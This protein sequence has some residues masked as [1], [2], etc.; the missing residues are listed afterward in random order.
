ML[1]KFPS[2]NNSSS[3]RRVQCRS[4]RSR[5]GRTLPLFECTQ[6]PFARILFFRRGRKRR[7]LISPPTLSQICLLP[8]TGTAPSGS[9]RFRHSFSE[10]S[11]SRWA[12]LAQCLCRDGDPG[13]VSPSGPNR[14]VLGG[15]AA[16]PLPMHA[17]PMD[18]RSLP[19][20]LLLSSL[21]PGSWPMPAVSSPP[22]YPRG[23]GMPV[24]WTQGDGASASRLGGRAVEVV[25]SD[26]ERSFDEK[27]DRLQPDERTL[28]E[29]LGRGH[30]L[31]KIAV[32]QKRSRTAIGR[33]HRRLL[34]RL[35]LDTPLAL[36][37]RAVR[38][39]RRTSPRSAAIRRLGPADGDRGS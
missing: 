9:V 21:L 39:C 30:T 19:T 32:A 8:A 12:S 15:T 16:H 24:R 33:L 11:R 20:A 18:R 37:R 35:D 27:V 34:Q 14:F 2:V 22:S 29:H 31:R 6:P 13:A 17:S 3:K 38:W 25:P 10:V 28:F 1:N 7:G 23:D 4:L 5:N 36:R 26:A